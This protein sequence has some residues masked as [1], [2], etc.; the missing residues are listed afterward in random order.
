MYNKCKEVLTFEVAS[1]DIGYNCIIGSPFLL[2]FMRVIHI[3]YATLKMLGPKGVIT[4]KADQHDALACE[5]ATLMHAVRFNEKAAQDQGAKVAKMRGSITSFKLSVPKPPV[6]AS[7]RPPSAKKDAYDA[8]MSNQQLADQL[9]DRKKEEVDDK[10]VP[11]NPCN[12]NKKL[13]I[14]KDLEAK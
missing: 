12:S 10:E 9:T 13:W 2:K 3:T 8:S 6:I 11:V 1:F 7:P 4:I 5:N 14:S